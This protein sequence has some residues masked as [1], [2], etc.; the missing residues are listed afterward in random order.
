[1]NFADDYYGHDARLE[2]A[3]RHG[4]R[5]PRQSRRSEPLP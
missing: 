4:Y 3:L 1:V 5:Y 2:K